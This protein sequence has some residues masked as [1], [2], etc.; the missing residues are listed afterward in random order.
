MSVYDFQRIEKLVSSLVLVGLTQTRQLFIR[1]V[2]SFD[3]LVMKKQVIAIFRVWE[4]D[5]LK[6]AR[7]HL[8]F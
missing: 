4:K 1:I 3:I 8:H 6:A 2:K 7:K 5:N